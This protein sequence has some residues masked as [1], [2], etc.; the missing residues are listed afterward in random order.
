MKNLLRTLMRFGI[1][2]SLSDRDGFISKVS[3]LFEKYSTEPG[4][5]ER[6]AKILATYLE[7]VKDRINLHDSVYDSIKDEDLATKKD[8][9][10]LTLLIQELTQQIQKEK[11][12]TNV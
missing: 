8:I 3:Q 5:A 12:P 2:V 9:E 1:V 4:K 7:D 6:I 11:S 10:E